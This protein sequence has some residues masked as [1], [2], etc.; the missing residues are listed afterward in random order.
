LRDT[1]TETEPTFQEDLL[2]TLPVVKLLT[3]PIPALADYW[4]RL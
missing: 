3:A 2:G 1:V 4:R